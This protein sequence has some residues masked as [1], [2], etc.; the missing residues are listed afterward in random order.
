MLFFFSRVDLASAVLPV[1]P[2]VWDYYLVISSH[3]CSD[4]KLGHSI[5]IPEQ[6]AYRPHCNV[7]TSISPL[8]SA[9]RL[10]SWAS[11]RS[12]FSGWIK[13]AR[14]SV[15][16]RMFRKMRTSVLSLCASSQVGGLQTFMVYRQTVTHYACW[17][18]IIDAGWKITV[19]AYSVSGSVRS[20]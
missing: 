6:T 17:V 4:E 15:R 1:L 18:S 12:L 19:W 3:A 10:A 16:G 8:F 2:S 20:A 5:K 13:V 7:G 9:H 14:K 11:A